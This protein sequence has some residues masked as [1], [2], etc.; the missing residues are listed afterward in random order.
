[1]T[2]ATGW[3]WATNGKGEFVQDVGILAIFFRNQFAKGLLR[4]ETA[5]VVNIESKVTNRKKVRQGKN[6]VFVAHLSNGEQRRP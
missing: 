5:L 4:I 2:R 1:M 3:G 6:Q